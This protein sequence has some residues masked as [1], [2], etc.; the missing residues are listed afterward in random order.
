MKKSK[1]TLNLTE[2]LLG[3]LEN[4]DHRFNVAK[5]N[6]GAFALQGFNIKK[7]LQRRYF[8]L[9]TDKTD[10]EI[11]D[12]FEIPNNLKVEEL[13]T[14]LNKYRDIHEKL[15]NYGARI[16]THTNKLFKIIYGASDPIELLHTPARPIS[17]KANTLLSM[18]SSISRILA[19]FISKVAEM[20]KKVT[21]TIQQKYRDTFA[22]R[23]KQARTTAELTQLQLA[24]RLSV[25]RITLTQYERAVNEP[26]FS[27][28]IKMAKLLNVSLDWLTGL[29]KKNVA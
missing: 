17:E 26:N 24:K 2:G 13:E 29:T 3:K 5:V 14:R 12:N 27:M 19:D 15:L 11:M 4:P 20:I 25:A 23:L 6:H 10:L 18:Y 8:D 22:N 7:I 28:L 9:D 1:M 21:E 16:A